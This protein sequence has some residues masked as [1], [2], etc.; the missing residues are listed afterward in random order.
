MIQSQEDTITPFQ[1]L[2]GEAQVVQVADQHYFVIC[3]YCV[4]CAL[5]LKFSNH[6]IF[7]FTDNV[8]TTGEGHC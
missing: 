1:I 3:A 2:G 6:L 5:I 7:L 8:K 4:V